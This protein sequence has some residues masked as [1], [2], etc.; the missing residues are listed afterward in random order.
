M[1]KKQLSSILTLAVLLFFGAYF[2]SNKPGG[3][4]VKGQSVVKS[5]C[6]FDQLVYY[7][8]DQCQWCRKV[9]N[10][11]TLSKVE[12][13]GVKVKKVNANV[14]PVRHQFEGVPTFVVNEEVT[15]GYQTFE[16]LKEKL[17]CKND[18]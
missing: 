8:L 11:E 16:Q 15:S 2:L 10:E 6:E 1:K 13:L 3:E 18:S 5:E 12:Q 7:Y 14:G 17:G 4:N 9:K